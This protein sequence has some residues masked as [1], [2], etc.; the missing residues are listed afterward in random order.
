MGT[1]QVAIVW[2]PTKTSREAIE[3]ALPRD[4]GA[5][6]EWYETTEHDAGQ[7][8]AARA[9]AAGAEVVIAA[10]GDGTVRAVAEHLAEMGADADL[11]IIPLGTGNLLARNFGV[12]LTSVR[13][14]L[15]RALTGEAK[16]LDIGWAEIEVDGETEVH[17]FTV[18]AGFGIDAHM[19]TE[20]DDDLK[21][22]AGWLAYVES[23]GRAL[24]ASEV[25]DIRGQLDGGD[26]VDAS[27]HTVIV[28]NCGTLQGGFELLPGAEP[29]DGQLDMLVL[30]AEG[31]GGWLEAAR[32]A[33]WDNGIKRRITRSEEAASSASV[34]H[35]RMRS[36][37][38]ELAEPREFEVDGDT[39][40][41]VERV[42]FTVQPGALRIR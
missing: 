35:H 7:G 22:R 20:T 13:A 14:A 19:I 40:G 3:R 38:L 37:E 36:L 15:K 26:P 42:R 2:N 8:A 27:A 25:I 32:T 6:I 1:Q 24:S 21:A 10:G 9:L 5:E 29:A 11:A 28:G 41:E 34:V 30:S 12:P 18:M 33:V 39:L 4:H 17:A 16:P 31:L 23:L